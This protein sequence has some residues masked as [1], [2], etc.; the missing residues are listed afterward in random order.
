[1]VLNPS[2]PQTGKQSHFP[3]KVSVLGKAKDDS[4]KGLAGDRAS[5]APAKWGALFSA[6]RS[7]FYSAKCFSTTV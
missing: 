7:I 1:M 2:G 3:M 4:H 5:R 6:H